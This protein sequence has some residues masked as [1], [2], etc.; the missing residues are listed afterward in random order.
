MSKVAS[1]LA[2]DTGRAGARRGREPVPYA[3]VVTLDELLAAIVS[4]EAPRR[5]TKTLARARVDADRLVEEVP[6][7]LYVGDTALHLAGAALA[8]A[9]TAALLRAGADAN[10]TN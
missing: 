10:A 9:A 6:H 7:W 4:D 2:A 3:P 1:F 8:P 5:V